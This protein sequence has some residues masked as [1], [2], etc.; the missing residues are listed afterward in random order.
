MKNLKKLV[1]ASFMLVIAFV[2][3]VSSTYAWFTRGTDAKV[4]DITISVVDAQKSL[5]IG[6]E[7]GVW[8]R[9][10]TVDPVG[11]MTPVTLVSG[12]SGTTVTRFDQLKWSDALVPSLEPA[13][14]LKEGAENAEY[15]A[16]DATFD[17]QTVYYTRSG[18]GT[19]ASPYVYAEAEGI[20]EFAANT[21]YFVKNP[22]YV[23]EGYI[24]FDL[25]FQITVQEGRQ[26]QGRLQVFTCR[27]SA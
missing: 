17:A 23:A 2:A 4:N 6:R 11:K 1:I 18:S 5:L 10:V 24:K 22:A 15:I 26:R 8:S 7:N 12:N 20:T 14:V 9:N 19:S 16:A 27:F 25:Y 21:D 13:E 3:V